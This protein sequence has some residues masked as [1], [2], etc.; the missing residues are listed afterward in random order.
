MLCIIVICVI[1]IDVQECKDHTDDCEQQCTNTA[2]SYTCSCMDGYVLN[3]D[4]KTC[5]DVNECANDATNSCQ[6][7][8]VNTVGSYNCTCD[9]GYILNADGQTCSGK[10]TKCWLLQVTCQ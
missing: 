10:K 4:G 9:Q 8:C 3:S 7:V 6:Q 2:G 5:S 1:W